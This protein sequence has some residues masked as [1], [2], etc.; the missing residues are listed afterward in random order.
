MNGWAFRVKG[1]HSAAWAEAGVSRCDSW[2]VV[3]RVGN[4]SG[5]HYRVSFSPEQARLLRRALSRA[6]R[7]TAVAEVTP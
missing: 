3:V 7:E 5:N 1:G 2:R 6:I 4:S